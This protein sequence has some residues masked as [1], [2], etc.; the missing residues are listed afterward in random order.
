MNKKS[1]ILT[2]FLYSSQYNQKQFLWLKLVKTKNFWCHLMTKGEQSFWL[3]LWGVKFLSWSIYEKEEWYQNSK[4]NIRYLE[5]SGVCL[6]L[7]MQIKL[8]CK[9]VRSFLIISP[10]CL[11]W[12]KKVIAYFGTIIDCWSNW[13]NKIDPQIL[14]SELF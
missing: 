1:L 12:G 7:L 4:G 9:K 10:K 13:K 8:S 6:Y 5:K 14:S 11:R 3:T 2:I